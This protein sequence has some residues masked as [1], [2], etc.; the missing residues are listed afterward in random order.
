MEQHSKGEIDVLVVGAG[1]VGLALGCELAR[2]GLTCRVVEM[3]AERAP[4]SK[5]QIVHA[6]TQEILDDMGAIA[7]FLARGR[8]LHS[9]SL[10]KHSGERLI[11]IH[12][13]AVDSRYGHMLSIPQRDTEALLE[14]HLAGLGVAVER[15][16]KLER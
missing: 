5:A 13:E 2:H 4:W 12:L 16:V 3:N 6:R 15:P 11:Q 10:H 7:A 1:P 14:E 8:L 9:L